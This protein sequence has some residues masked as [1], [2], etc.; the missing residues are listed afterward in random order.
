M[1]LHGCSQIMAI[2]SER[3]SF[4]TGTVISCLHFLYQ[5]RAIRDQASIGSFITNVHYT[6][7]IYGSIRKGHRRVRSPVRVIWI[8]R[9]AR[10]CHHVRTQL[11]FHTVS[12]HDESGQKKDVVAYVRFV[13]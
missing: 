7:Q 6:L 1:R 3:E 4:L 11:E 13:H 10:S 9:P 12:L 8:F 5:S 2:V